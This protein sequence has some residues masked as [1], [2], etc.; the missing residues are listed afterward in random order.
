MRLN[1]ISS[2]WKSLA[3]RKRVH[4]ERE[5]AMT[6]SAAAPQC[7]YYCVI[8]PD[9]PYNLS[10]LSY[11]PS[12]L[13]K[14]SILR[15][16]HSSSKPLQFF[17]IL[18]VLPSIPHLHNLRHSSSSLLTDPSIPNRLL[19]KPPPRY[20]TQLSV[21]MSSLIDTLTASKG[22]EAAGR[23]PI[24]KALLDTHWTQVSSITLSN[25]YGRTSPSLRPTSQR[26]LSSRSLHQ[27][28]QPLSQIC[29]L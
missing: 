4:L 12:Q 20:R 23:L 24:A 27:H 7:R 19:P 9:F 28:F 1:N 2:T 29:V 14:L 16:P 25:N 26:K 6:T 3:G 18:T 22:P 13:Y 15:H 21:T 10:V 5:A 11:K 8:T 17:Q